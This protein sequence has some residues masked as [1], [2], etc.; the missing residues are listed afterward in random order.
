MRG[1]GNQR[2][3]GVGH[4]AQCRAADDPQAPVKF[5]AEEHLRQFRPRIGGKGAD[6]PEVTPTWGLFDGAAMWPA[7]HP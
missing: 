7:G 3:A 2:T 4:H 5:E 1:Q 6:A